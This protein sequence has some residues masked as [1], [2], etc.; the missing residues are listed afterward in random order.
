ML[1]LTGGVSAGKLDLVPGVLQ[2]LGVP[3]HFHKVEDFP[4][5]ELVHSLA[6]DAAT[7]RLYVPEQQENGKPPRGTK[8]VSI[9]VEKRQSLEHITKTCW[10][11]C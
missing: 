2:E 5:Q 9:V 10:N 7:H 1:I 8:G 6:V 4:V 3:A 11:N